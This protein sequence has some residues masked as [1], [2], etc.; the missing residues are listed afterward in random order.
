VEKPTVQAT[1]SDDKQSAR[2]SIDRMLTAAGI[3]TLIAELAVTR[4]HMLPAVSDS[5]SGLDSEDQSHH[6][7]VQ[8]NSNVV[9]ARLRDGRIRFWMRNIGIG[10]MVFNVPI[11]AAC[12][13]R[14]YLI[15]NTP[16]AKGGRGLFD[17]NV[18]DPDISH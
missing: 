18:G 11:Q 13:I 15:A 7:S 8:E 5:P 4:A 3:E 14:D 16:P 6:L 1:M 12:A 10:W 17:K 2:V 9:V